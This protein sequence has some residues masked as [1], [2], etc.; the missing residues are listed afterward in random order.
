MKSLLNQPAY[1]HQVFSRG[2]WSILQHIVHEPQS[3]NVAALLIF[4]F[5]HLV[6][7]L[8]SGNYRPTH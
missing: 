7:V 6:H 5:E 1:L 4:Q 2:R 3:T 8:K